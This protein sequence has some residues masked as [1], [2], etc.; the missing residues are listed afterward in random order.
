MVVSEAKAT[1]L[2]E[3]LGKGTDTTDCT[4]KYS[5]MLE[6]DGYSNCDAGHIL[7]KHLGG[8]GNEPLNIF[9]QNHS[10]NS[11]IFAAIFIKSLST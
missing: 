10:I 5:R 2:P 1:L 9:P 3:S 7:A 4:R 6:D 8:Y 11:G